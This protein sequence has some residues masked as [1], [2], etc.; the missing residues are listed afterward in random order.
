MFARDT[1][2]MCR[3]PG[4]SIVD[5]EVRSFSHKEWHDFRSGISQIAHNFNNS[6][7]FIVYYAGLNTLK[8]PY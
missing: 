7:K 5:S 1:I 6:G 4:A 8:L 3:T 2:L